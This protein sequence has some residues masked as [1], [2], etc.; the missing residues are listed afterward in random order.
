MN[1][2][3]LWQA[4]LPTPRITAAICTA[5]FAIVF[6]AVA[7]PL[8]RGNVAEAADADTLR[9]VF[10]NRLDAAFA[11]GDEEQIAGLADTTRWHKAGNPEL[12]SLTMTPLP[13]AP[14][15]REKTSDDSAQYRDGTGRLWRVTF[16]TSDTDS[17][18]LAEI[19]TNARFR[20]GGGMQRFPRA[21][22]QPQKPPVTTWTLLERWPPPQAGQ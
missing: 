19:H 4:N 21:G 1:V 20:S 15:R 8:N 2:K 5:V 7:P 10:L 6:A 3:F 13:K 11:S 17:S 18:W 9:A 22:V 16:R 12:S 14:L